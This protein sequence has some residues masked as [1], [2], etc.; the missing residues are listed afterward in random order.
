MK[1]LHLVAIGAIAAL[2]LAGCS[3]SNTT[4]SSSPTT[5]PAPAAGWHLDCTLGPDSRLSN[6]T[7]AQD[8]IAKASTTPGTKQEMW[9]AINPKDPLNVVVG[10]KDMNP[11]SSDKCVWNGLGVTKDGGKTWKDITIG[12]TFASR[13]PTSPFYGYACNTDPDFQFTANGDL[14]YG[15]EMYGLDAQGNPLP[16][17]SGLGGG[18]KILL[19]TS[20]DGGLSWPDVI[21]Y[22]P[23]LFLVTDFSR[24]TVVPTTQTILEAI[25][26]EGGV[27]CNVLRLAAGAPAAT[28]EPVATKDGVPCNSGAGSAIAAS[29]KGVAVMAGNSGVVARSTDD[30]V[31]WPDSNPGFP[32]KQI[33]GNFKESKYR[34]PGTIE[35]AYDLSNST[36][37][38]TLY[39]C[40][41]SADR[42][43]ADVYV[44]SST[45]NGKTWS[46]AAL[47]NN[48]LAGT[49]QWMCNIG[50]AGDGSIHAFFMDKR[51]DPK[52][53]LIDIT[54]AW[55]TDGGKNW[56]NE[57]VS[58]TSF[59]GDLGVH[60]SGVPFIGDYLG[61]ACGPKD[62][63]AGF[64]DSSNG[65]ATVIAAAHVH[66]D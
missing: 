46:D 18:F 5:S 66:L 37:N 56:T 41:P 63:W 49:H 28:F 10:S 42:D 4:N 30:G 52:H 36:R 25:G 9:L 57:R 16:D 47:V 60:Q 62:C 29:P 31:T 3:G 13:D 23:D 32:I 26:S 50:V 65:K 35:L 38:G 40:Y 61:A 58:T 20:H 17:P 19:A 39:A 27:G 33:P 8:C 64:P 6:A 24:M 59:D 48:D 7:W 22:Q 14:H 44:R 12:G 34:T 55:S 21:T 11:T 54:H 2:A 1:A 51:Y 45:D 53:K 43:E 15:V